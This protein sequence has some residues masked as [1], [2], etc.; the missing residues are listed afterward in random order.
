MKK[1]GK[2]CLAAIG[3]FVVGVTV[4]LPRMPLAGESLVA[5]L[6][7]YGPGGKG[8]NLAFAASR[9]G[10]EVRL[11]VKIGT[12]DFAQLADRLFTSEGI[13]TSWVYRS[14]TEAT[15][16]GLV[17]LSAET[18]ENM[19][20]FFPGA[21]MTLTSDEVTRA[22]T[23]L[24]GV[25][26]VTAQLEVPDDSVVTA[27]ELAKR[28]GIPT[29]LNPAPARRIPVDLLSLTGTITPNNN[30]LFQLL[31]LEVPVAPTIE[32][33][34]N[35]ARI[36]QSHGPRNVVVTMGSRGAFVLAGDNIPV[37]VPPIPVT[38]VDTVGAGDS[39]NAGLAV[40]L[41]SRKPI[42]ESA[43]FATICGGLATQKI[44]TV[45][46]MPYA[47]EIDAYKSTH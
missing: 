34:E 44:G 19:I 10:A 35:A 8:T 42:L 45:N 14:N 18:G 7:D 13:D 28:F 36:L 27:F 33:I 17:Y 23:D 29:L 46:A 47:E 15:G 5:D 20:G 31:G 22:F 43:R 39:F 3:S 16:I 40:S 11:V 38:P 1:S 37:V 12:D 4:R 9:L 21:N 32:E 2:P 6:F 24:A 26:I 25:D 30:E 41:A